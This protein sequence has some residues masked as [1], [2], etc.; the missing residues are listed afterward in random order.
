MMPHLRHKHKHANQKNAGR[1]AK[2]NADDAE[3]SKGGGSIEID[4]NAA[5]QSQAICKVSGIRDGIDGDYQITSAEH[6][7][8]RG[9][10]WVTKMELGQPGK[11]TGSDTRKAGSA[12][13]HK[14]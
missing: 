12:A 3:R 2:S 1:Q 13:S 11:G 6:T 10:G 8:S 14:K 5:A 7:Y 4:G 9:G